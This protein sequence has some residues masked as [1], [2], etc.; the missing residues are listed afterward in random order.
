[1][2]PN[3]LV[4]AYVFAK[5]MSVSDIGAHPQEILDP[6]L[7]T[8]LPI[9]NLKYLKPNYECQVHKDV[10]YLRT[11]IWGINNFNFGDIQYWIKPN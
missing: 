10:N 9:T 5:N 8:Y 7:I 1:M 2:E 3:S 11:L 4:F 6:P